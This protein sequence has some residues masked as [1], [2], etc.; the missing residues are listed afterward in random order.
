MYDDGNDERRRRRR[1]LVV[2]SVVGGTDSHP[3]DVVLRNQI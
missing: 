1:R 3:L 2:R